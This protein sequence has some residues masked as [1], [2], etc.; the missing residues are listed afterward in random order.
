[1]ELNLSNQTHVA[2]RLTPELESHGYFSH[3]G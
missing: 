1:M 2:R 3:I